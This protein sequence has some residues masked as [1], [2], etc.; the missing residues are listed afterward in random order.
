MLTSN[1]NSGGLQGE[2]HSFSLGK[3]QATESWGPTPSPLHT[4]KQAPTLGL[5]GALR[6]GLGRHPWKACTQKSGL[7][8]SLEAGEGS[9]RVRG[10]GHVGP[11]GAKTEPGSSQRKGGDGQ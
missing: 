2:G 10:Q 7:L 5:W 1:E 8:E 11:D 4:L 9:R 6:G 3:P